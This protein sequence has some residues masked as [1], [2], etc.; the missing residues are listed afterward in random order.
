[1]NILEYSAANTSKLF[2]EN[3][4]CWF[5]LDIQEYPSSQKLEILEIP[6]SIFLQV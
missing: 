1:M 6:S 5:T 3:L 2:Q 4:S